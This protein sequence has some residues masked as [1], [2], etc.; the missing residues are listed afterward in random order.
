MIWLVCSYFLLGAIAASW[1][2]W[3]MSK[4]AENSMP[5]PVVMTLFLILVV[6][7]WPMLVTLGVV[8]FVVDKIRQ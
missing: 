5:H 8:V 4:H 1:E 2:A 3:E 7:L 6:L